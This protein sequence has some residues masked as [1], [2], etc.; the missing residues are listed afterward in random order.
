MRV[1]DG[2]RRTKDRR[3]E[4]YGEKGIMTEQTRGE[5]MQAVYVHGLAGSRFAK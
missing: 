5:R 3:Q 2:C 1:G 4:I